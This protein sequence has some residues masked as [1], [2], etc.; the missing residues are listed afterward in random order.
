MK[1]T[2]IFLASLAMGWLSFASEAAL[3]AEE[4]SAGEAVNIGSNR[5]LFVDQYL[6]GSLDGTAQKQWPPRDEGPI[7]FLDSPWEGE[8]SIYMTVLH[9][10]SKYQL[11]YRGKGSTCYAESEDGI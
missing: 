5:E 11:Y 7:L 10:G 4:P 6:I 3:R 9:V 1:Q 2:M 8:L